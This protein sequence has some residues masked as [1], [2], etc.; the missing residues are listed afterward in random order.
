MQ[1]H[2]NVPTMLRGLREIWDEKEEAEMDGVKVYQLSREH[3]VIHMLLHFEKHL[4]TEGNLEIKSLVDVL[5]AVKT[6]RIDWQKLRSQAARWKVQGVISPVAATLNHYY[7]CQAGIPFS[8]KSVAFDL[9][10]LIPKE[11]EL[12]KSAIQRVPAG[13]LHRLSKARELP[14]FAAK[15]RFLFHIFFPIRENLHWRYG[16]SDDKSMGAYYF[17]HLSYIGKRFFSGIGL[18]WRAEEEGGRWRRKTMTP[19]L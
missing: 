13:F 15:V 9:E 19:G 4:R 6:W 10:E 16:S 8:E 14:G 17:L 18:L 1:F 3:Y 2:S 5:Q 7:Y 12:Q 11:E